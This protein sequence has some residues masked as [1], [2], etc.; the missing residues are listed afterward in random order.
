MLELSRATGVAA[1]ALLAVVGYGGLIY[2]NSTNQDG[3]GGTPSPVPSPAVTFP[4]AR[5]MPKPEGPL[6]AGRYV[7]HPLPA[8]HADLT[9]TF[10]VPDEW[11]ALVGANVLVPTGQ[12]TASGPGGMAIQFIDVTTINEDACRWSG[13]ADDVSVGPEVDDLVEALRAEE[14][15]YAVSDPVDVT[16]GGFSGKRVDILN[17]KIF[18]SGQGPEAPGCDEDVIRLWDTTAHG[19]YAFYAQGPA[20]RWQVNILDVDG[21]RLV[22]VVQDFAETLPADRAEMDAIVDSLVIEP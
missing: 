6:E 20:N 11:R 22:V 10:T 9:V 8:P 5:P 15:I 1:V 14:T 13:T 17:P 18:F 19:A 21:T 12:P 16:M 2:L 3:S 4:A 7:A